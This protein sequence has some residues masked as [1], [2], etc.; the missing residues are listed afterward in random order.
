[1]HILRT[2]V[3]KLYKKF[4]LCKDKLVLTVAN[5]F[6]NALKQMLRNKVTW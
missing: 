5:D 1:M 4:K 2:V 6:L 3:N